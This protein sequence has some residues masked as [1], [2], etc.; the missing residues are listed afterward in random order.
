MTLV[1][2]RAMVRAELGLPAGPA[3]PDYTMISTD[4]RTLRPG[5][6]F[7][8][9]T[10]ERFD[11]HGFLPAAREGGAVAA[12]VRRG[13]P[14]V[15][16][17]ELLQVEDPLRAYGTLARAR[18]R[19][20]AGPVV[21][22]TGSNG[23][24]ST[25]EMV[26]AVLRARYRT[27]A[28]RANLNNLVGVPLTILEAPDDT[29]ALVVEAGASLAGELV[30]YREIIEPDITVLTMVG[31][32]HLEGFGGF[33]PYLEEKLA[34]TRDVPLVVVGP[35]PADLGARALALGAGRVRTVGLE[36]ADLV[37]EAV[38][39]L[40][41]GHSRVTVEG[42]TF[43]LPLLGRHQVVNALLAWAVGQATGVPPTA[44]AQA[45]A[46]VTIPAGRGEVQ[47]LGGLTLV[48]DSYNANPSS[49][50]AAI[51]LARRMR[52]RRPLVFVAGTMRELGTDAAAYHRE[53]AEA[54]VALAPD[55]LC[56]V[57]DFVPALAPW[58]APLGHR[59]LTAPDALALAAPLAA[60]LSG[61]ELV[62]LKASRGVALERIIPAIA[63]R[64]AAAT[65][66]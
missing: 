63:S 39:T 31:P 57:G 4:T 21:A 43:L 15:E 49:F 38:E 52:G 26:A 61:Q 23:K 59:L 54:L 45:L 20:I 3:G 8:A 46:A 48:N 24:T 56:A 19:E 7:V 35:E 58:A 40:P 6:L 13:T 28:T 14:A 50:L 17:L 42:T 30:R 44:A 34:L 9:L 33:A 62:V 55:L 27:S 37:P 16:G 29:E 64:A 18:R 53:V 22:I 66:A 41:D 12:V 11:G 47:Q 60:R 2:A 1:R 25:K 65:E 32:C 10:G 51:D 36:G 5:A